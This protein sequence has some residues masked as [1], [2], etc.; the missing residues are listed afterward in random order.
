MRNSLLNRI[1]I[2]AATVILLLCALLLPINAAP[3]SIEPGAFDVTPCEINLLKL[4]ESSGAVTCGT[5]TVPEQHA[6]PQ[7]KT[8]QLGVVIIHSSSERPAPD[9]LVM[10]Q[11]GPGGSTIDLYG[12]VMAGDNDIRAERD[13]VLFDQRGTMYA[14]PFLNCPESLAMTEAT[15]EQDLSLREE[16]QK[17][18][19]A[20]LACKTRLEQEG[21]NLAAFNSLENA[22]DIEALRL[23]LGYEQINL[24]GVSYGTLLAQHVMRDYPQSLRSVI[25]D[26]VVPTQINFVTQVPTTMA[27]AHATLFETCAADPNCRADYPDLEATFFSLVERLNAHPERFRL[28]D[29]ETGHSFRAV[30]SGDDLIDTTFLLFYSSDL[31]PLLPKI[32]TDIDR[33]N[34]DAL[35]SLLPLLVFDRT[36]SDGMYYSVMC[37]EDADYLMSQIATEGI[38]P[39]FV[40]SN[41]LQAESFLAL[42]N[43]WG[44]SDLGSR[45][46]QPVSSDIPTLVLSG[47]FDPITPP[48]FADA[49]AETLSNSYVYTFP[50]NGHGA[51]LSGPCADNLIADFINAPTVTPDSSCIEQI[52]DIEFMPPNGIFTTPAPA[53]L[54]GL[55]EGHYLLGAGLIGLSLTALLSIYLI[56]PLAWI[57]RLILNR[58]PV[59]RP[60]WSWAAAFLALALGGINLL[61]LAG[62]VALVFSVGFSNEILLLIGVPRVWGIL[63]VLPLLAL[64]PMIGMLVFAVK[65]WAGQNWSLWRRVYYS[66][67]TLSALVLTIGFM[68]WGVMSVLF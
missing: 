16:N 31:I 27:R 39:E 32:I 50:N 20:E 63:F 68:R 49:A 53:K 29:A 21:V 52:P 48:Y 10:L 35:S 46:D 33:G 5:L 11:G 3:P 22:A 9:P 43:Q 8:I 25:L 18:L 37:A 23:A 14:E 24:Y 41:L 67:I 58:K 4:Q 12:L 56:W 40:T 17:S 36:M 45:V 28:T 61:F 60:G 34:F 15:L 65:S 19:E 62:M 57:A 51:Y 13:I 54:L 47:R 1:P 55:F 42:C 66:T 6:N 38:R 2:V 26:A 64:L 59:N 44:V 30:F 7:G